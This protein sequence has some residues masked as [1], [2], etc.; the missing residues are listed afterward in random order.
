[1]TKRSFLFAAAI[2]VASLAFSAPSH[3]GTV[4]NVTSDVLV[5]TGVAT[6]VTENFSGPVSGPVT[7][8]GTTLTLVGAPIIAGN[9]I[10]FNFNPV[11]VGTYILDYMITGPVGGLQFL[12][13][14]LSPAGG[15]QGGAAGVASPAVPEPTSLALLGI[16]MTGFLAFR[17]LFKRRA[18]A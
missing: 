7:V 11:G 16:G 12:G 10:T 17:R 5:I 6:D 1:M 3:A 15:P 2:A 13:G 8:T 9:T 14:T 18:I 4:Y